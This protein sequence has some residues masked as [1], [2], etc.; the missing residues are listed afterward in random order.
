MSFV[1]EKTNYD[2]KT[3]LNYKIKDLK[4]PPQDKRRSSRNN[5]STTSSADQSILGDLSD[6]K[7]HINCKIEDLGKEKTTIIEEI[8]TPIWTKISKEQTQTPEQQNIILSTI[9]E[10]ILRQKKINKKEKEYIPKDILEKFGVFSDKLTRIKNSMKDFS[11]KLI[12]CAKK[13]LTEENKIAEPNYV[14]EEVKVNLQNYLNMEKRRILHSPA[15]K[16]SSSTQ[17]ASSSS[18]TQAA[19]SS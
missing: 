16:I 1:D 6:E 17:A 14:P 3:K 13:K 7:D 19:S 11:K 18:S 12:R 5:I 2:D 10:K 8:K 15:A 9:L 4:Q